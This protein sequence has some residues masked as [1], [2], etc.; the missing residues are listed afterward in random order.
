MQAGNNRQPF[1]GD[2]L[3][4]ILA[5]HLSPHY[6]RWQWID[7]VR[8]AGPM[9][10]L[11][12]WIGPNPGQPSGTQYDRYRD[13][14][15]PN[16]GDP[17]RWVVFHFHINA[18]FD[19]YPYLREVNGRTYIGVQSISVFHA[20]EFNSRSGGGAWRVQG[21]VNVDTRVRR[22]GFVCPEDELWY[23]GTDEGLPL[24]SDEL[25]RNLRQWARNLFEDDYLASESIALI[26]RDLVFYNNGEINVEDS[27]N[28]DFMGYYQQPIYTINWVRRY[29]TFDFSPSPPQ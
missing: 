11:A 6:A 16:H 22:D 29:G 1:I 26:M 10:E 3:E 13:T 9:L 18:D 25:Q 19:R 14:H 20:N 2:I 12:Y 28:A 8:A 7:G 27:E 15:T 4:G 21:N 5:G 23:I 17:D 24:I